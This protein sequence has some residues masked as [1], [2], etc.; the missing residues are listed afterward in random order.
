MKKRDVDRP[1]GVAVLSKR[2]RQALKT[3]EAALVARDP[4]WA[5][6][7]TEN[8][9]RHHWSWGSTPGRL[10]ILLWLGFLS[11]GIVTENLV[12]DTVVMIFL[13]T[14]PVA[15]LLLL[16]RRDAKADFPAP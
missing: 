12:V 16:A 8:C 15:A 4:R 6:Q 11:V 1:S 7:F 3:M 14:G 13:F 10:T 2:E 9:Q 5:R